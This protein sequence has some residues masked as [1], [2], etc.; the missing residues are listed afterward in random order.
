M[1]LELVAVIHD[2]DQG[3][4]C[5]MCYC[6]VNRIPRKPQGRAFWSEQGIAEWA[7]PKPSPGGKAASRKLTDAQVR[8]IRA[9][10]QAGAMQK[11]IVARWGLSKGQVSKVVNH[12]TYAWIV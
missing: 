6:H 12:V 7:N 3:K 5:D 2:A 11:D 1:R 9:Q 4:S 10:A 8:A